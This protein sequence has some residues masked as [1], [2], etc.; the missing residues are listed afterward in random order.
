MKQKI[1]MKVPMNDPKS[2]SKAMKTAVGIHGVISATLEGG[3]KE[4]LVVVGEGVDSVVL[5]TLLRKKMG[6]TEL[7]SVA[8]VDEK[9]KEEETKPS[10]ETAVLPTYWAYQYSMPQP[11]HYVYQDPYQDNCCIM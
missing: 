6:F 2:R 3:N 7:V 5:T 8:V 10:S 4:E 1:V 11:L 9:K